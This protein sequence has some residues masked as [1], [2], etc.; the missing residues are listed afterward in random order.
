MSGFLGIGQ[1]GP[2]HVIYGETE[3]GNVY[4]CCPQGAGQWERVERPEYAW[5]QACL[6]LPPRAS[7]PPRPVRDC[8]EI[9]AYEW[10]TFRTQFAL[11]DDGTVWMWHLETSV[12]DY[13][14]VICGSSL[15]GGVVGLV[16]GW[17]KERSKRHHSS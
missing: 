4:R 17:R 9:G 11:L 8:V 10:G 5:D 14:N 7:P 15:L 16:F 12:A 13:F 2:D 3:A 1:Y 6:P